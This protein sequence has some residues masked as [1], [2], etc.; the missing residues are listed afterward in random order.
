MFATLANLRRMRLTLLLCLCL[1]LSTLT[2]AR[3]LVVAH[4][5]GKVLGPE[6]T[7][8]TFEKAIALGVDAIEL[9]IHKTSDDG[10][11]VIHD[12]TLARTFAGHPGRVDQMTLEQA[13]AAGL[14]T[15]KQC[16]ELCKGRCQVFVEIK[17][18]HGTRHEGIEPLLIQTLQA[19]GMDDQVVVISFDPLSLRLLRELDEKLPLGYL[20]SGT[21][22]VEPAA[23]YLSPHYSKI[24][25]AYVEAAHA[26]GLKVSTW[27]VNDPEAMK[28]IL[29]LG[30]DA[31][32]TDD[33]AVLLEILAAP[34]RD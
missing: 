25:R 11:V 7:L 14:P 16:L 3:P 23:N 20:T 21:D 15:L 6:N 17:H 33:P 9:D 31:I 18:P 1:S 4:R 28:A 22:K 32:T 2:F 5:G 26:R 34:T 24:D 27:T 29:D 8:A 10:L 13:V 12:V 30:C 19:S